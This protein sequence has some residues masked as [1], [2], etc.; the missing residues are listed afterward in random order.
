MSALEPRPHVL[1][2]PLQEH[3]VVPVGRLLDGLV[4]PGP[5]E[6][7]ERA[8]GLEELAHGV[9][10]EG[11]DRAVQEVAGQVVGM[12][13][14]EEQRLHAGRGGALRGEEAQRLGGVSPEPDGVVG[15]RPREA[16]EQFVLLS[17]REDPDP[18]E[19]D[20]VAPQRREVHAHTL[21]AMTNLRRIFFTAKGTSA[22]MVR[23]PPE[24]GASPSRFFIVMGWVFILFGIYWPGRVVVDMLSL[25]ALWGEPSVDWGSFAVYYGGMLLQS[26]PNLPTGWSLLKRRSWAP[27]VA[28]VAG[29][30]ALVGFGWSILRFGQQGLQ[31]FGNCPPE[32]RRMRIVGLL[33]LFAH[34]VSW[35]VL[36][37]ALFRRDGRR[38]EFT[39]AR[40]WT[41]V[42][43][44]AL[45]MGLY[46][47]ASFEAWG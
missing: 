45:V 18:P 23:N 6:K 28:C 38:T 29:G 47:W 43:A 25:W 2:Q 44:G 19:P 33:A 31:E 5:P 13:A 39:T 32:G 14:V 35:L 42:G 27:A 15:R 24:D 36:L 12:V 4:P 3:H 20:A 17:E 30:I 8:A 1:G 10:V 34:A 26:V 7:V 40:F 41:A 37:G 11:A 22:P 21:H 46:C 16:V 9:V